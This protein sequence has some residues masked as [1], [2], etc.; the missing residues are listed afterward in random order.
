MGDYVN[1]ITVT[2]DNLDKEHICYTISNNK[3]CQVSSK[4]AWLAKRFNDGL[5]II[6]L[7]N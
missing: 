6:Q 5:V 1:I 3:D 7:V 4:K 2:K